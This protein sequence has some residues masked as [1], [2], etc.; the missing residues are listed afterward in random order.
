MQGILL[1]CCEGLVATLG[2]TLEALELINQ[3]A[4]LGRELVNAICIINMQEALKDDR[5]LIGG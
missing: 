1:G 4:V 3:R 2:D 5:A